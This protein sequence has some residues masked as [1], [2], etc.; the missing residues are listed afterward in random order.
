MAA[1]DE[2]LLDLGEALETTGS[3]IGMLV[4]VLEGVRNI[5]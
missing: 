4:V 5:P 3:Q 2:T 1:G